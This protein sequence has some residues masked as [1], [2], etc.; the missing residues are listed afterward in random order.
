[1]MRLQYRLGDEV[2]P[3]IVTVMKYMEDDMIQNEGAER[4]EGSAP[5]SKKARDLAKRLADLSK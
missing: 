2:D 3:D 1:M 5:R 4:K